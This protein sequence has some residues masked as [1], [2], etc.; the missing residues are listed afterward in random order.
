MR[1]WQAMRGA[2]AIPET[3]KEAWAAYLAHE[4]RTDDRIAFCPDYTSH[5]WEE[6]WSSA[7]EHLLDTLRTPTADGITA[8]QE[9]MDF[10]ANRD[11]NPRFEEDKLLITALRED[12]AS[13]AASVQTGHRTSRD[14]RAAVQAMLRAEPGLSDRE[15]ARRI[16]CSPQT[17]SNWR[18]RRA[19]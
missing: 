14:K 5:P 12:F 7:L 8:R 1:V 11:V 4:A 19:K 13:F 18:R 2:V 16:G 17:V 9:W 10:L 15:I 3:V 6:A